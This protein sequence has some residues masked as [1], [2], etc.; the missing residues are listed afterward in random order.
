MTQRRLLRLGK[1][2]KKDDI[3]LFTQTD[4]DMAEVLIADEAVIGKFDWNTHFDDSEYLIQRLALKGT[5][6]HIIAD[7]LILDFESDAINLSKA[8]QNIIHRIVAE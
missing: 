8:L 7:V 2:T 3:G 6:K 4:S 1:S 5:A